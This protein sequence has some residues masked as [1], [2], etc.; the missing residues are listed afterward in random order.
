VKKM[1]HVTISGVL[2]ATKEAIVY[3]DQFFTGPLSYN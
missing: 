3:T 2:A 1:L